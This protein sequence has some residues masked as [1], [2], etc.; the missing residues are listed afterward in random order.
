M[1]RPVFTLSE[2]ADLV[3]ISRST[4]RRKLDQGN[5]PDAYRDPKGVWKVPLT[6]LLAA[7][8]RPVQG[9]VQDLSTDIGQPVHD[10]GQSEQVDLKNRVIELENALSIERA[11]RTAAE[12]VAAAEQH[13]AQTAEMAL[14]MIEAAR[15]RHDERGEHTSM[16]AEQPT[17][18]PPVQAQSAQAAPKSRWQRLWGR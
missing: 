16:P 9:A 15:P 8:F 5:F 18:L 11:H 4:L 6:N 2:A 13:R 10:I 7:G 17:T 12:Q 1:S 3:S 14:R